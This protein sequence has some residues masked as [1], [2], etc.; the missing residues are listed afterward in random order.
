MIPNG[1]GIYGRSRFLDDGYA[2]FLASHGI[3]WYVPISLSRIKKQIDAGARHGIMVHAGLIPHPNKTQDQAMTGLDKILNACDNE[4]TACPHLDMEEGV[5]WNK[6]FCK[7]FVGSAADWS[8][9][10]NSIFGVTCY[11]SHKGGLSGMEGAY[12]YLAQVYDRY[13][14]E[15]K[16]Q[17]IMFEKSLDKFYKI[18]GTAPVG[19]GVGAF[20]N[21][22]KSDG[23]KVVTTKPLERFKRH[24]AGV[25]K[26]VK[27]GAVWTLP[28]LQSD[29]VKY[30]AWW[31]AIGEW[32]IG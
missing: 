22:A 10:Q 11:G 15:T 16:Y 31:K 3:K 7:R 2:K 19:V 28:S 5:F 20:L 9:I 18:S 13:L 30:K 6:A 25:P 27:F 23:T 4:P 17:E 29:T 1:K 32:Q 24:L 12:Y 14:K 26:K 21:Y 8:D